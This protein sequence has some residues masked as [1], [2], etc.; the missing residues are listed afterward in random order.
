MMK[1]KI[2]FI[3]RERELESLLG[4]CGKGYFDAIVPFRALLGLAYGA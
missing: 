2:N 1:R 4:L 3:G